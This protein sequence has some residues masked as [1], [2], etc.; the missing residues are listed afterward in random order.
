MQDTTGGP[1]PAT[2]TLVE[3]E[4][5]H[6][7]LEPWTRADRVL[8]LLVI[9]GWVLVLGLVALLGERQASLTDLE[10]AV[11]AGEVDEVRLAGSLSEQGRGTAT[12]EVHWRQGGVGYTA[13]VIEAR[14]L[15]LAPPA[16][17]RGEATVVAGDLGTWLRDIDPA[18]EVVRVESPSTTTE[19]LGWRVGG[20]L[21]WA[22]LGAWVATLLLLLHSPQPW[23]A[24]RWAWFWLLGLLPPVGLVA[25]LL[26]GGPV[27]LVPAPRDGARRLTGGWAFLIALVLGGSVL[28]AA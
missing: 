8:R 10:R 9:A 6:G 27:P 17:E 23:R 16:E 13:T 24:T 12:A 18:L 22:L 15:R 25:F 21:V 5:R 19:V 28:G 3:P 2:S 4:V 7:G 26:L 1:L 11:A 20:W 14:P